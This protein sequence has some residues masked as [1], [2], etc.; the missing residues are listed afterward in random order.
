MNIRGSNEIILILIASIIPN[1]IQELESNQS[2]GIEPLITE[3]IDRQ[4]MEIH[5]RN[6]SSPGP[7]ES[8]EPPA[9]WIA[10]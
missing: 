1:D 7:H 9:L 8:E 2:A 10:R 6:F 5:A 4:F 3:R